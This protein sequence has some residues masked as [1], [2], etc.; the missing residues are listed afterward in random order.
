MA[1]WKDQLYLPMV[2]SSDIIVY[3]VEPFAYEETITVGDLTRPSDIV[4]IE[5]VLY[6]SEFK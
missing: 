6:V 2:R 4:A 1:M 3:N 5:D